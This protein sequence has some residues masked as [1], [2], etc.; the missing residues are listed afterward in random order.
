MKE[1]WGIFFQVNYLLNYILKAHQDDC[2]FFVFLKKGA[3][4]SINIGTTDKRA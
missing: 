2:L 3:R 4:T 1:A